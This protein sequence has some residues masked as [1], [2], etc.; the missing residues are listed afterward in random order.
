PRPLGSVH[1]AMIHIPPGETRLAALRDEVG[2][3]GQTHG[4]FPAPQT[5]RRQPAPGRRPGRRGRSARRHRPTVLN[6]SSQPGSRREKGTVM[7]YFTSPEEVDKYIGEMFRQ[8]AG[9][10]QVG[11]KMKAAQITMRVVYEDPDCE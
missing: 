3:D 8:A 11:P 10:P 5:R 9:H 1:A 7:G 4:R 6:G 2:T